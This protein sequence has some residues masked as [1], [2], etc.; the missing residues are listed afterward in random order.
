MMICM[1]QQSF[2]EVL[3]VEFLMTPVT[4]NRKL[5][6]DVQVQVVTPF[7]RQLVTLDEYAT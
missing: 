5:F 6:S 1:R 3:G 2:R 7:P 4:G